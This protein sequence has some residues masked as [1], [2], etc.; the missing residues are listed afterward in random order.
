[1]HRLYQMVNPDM[2]LTG[3]RRR[4]WLQAGCPIIIGPHLTFTAYFDINNES[5]VPCVKVRAPGREL[6]YELPDGCLLDL[7]AWCGL[8]A[9]P[10]AVE[11]SPSGRPSRL[12]SEF[13]AMDERV[14]WAM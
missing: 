8:K 4:V 11:F 12:L 9:L 5:Y 10:R 3:P 7:S 1:M 14:Q 2:S 13:A 6:K